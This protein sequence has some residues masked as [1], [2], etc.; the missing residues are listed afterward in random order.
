V[1]VILKPL[2]FLLEHKL[3]VAFVLGLSLL[4][5]LMFFPSGDLK[6]IVTDHIN[7]NSG[8]LYV[9]FGSLDLKLVP[10][11]GLYA[12]NVQVQPENFP[13][14]VAGSADISVS[15]LSTLMN[16]VAAT[17][18]LSGIFKGD[19][20]VAVAQKEKV[21]SGDRMI[22]LSASLTTVSVHDAIDYLRS[23]GVSFVTLNGLLNLS[24]QLRWDPSLSSQ[25]NGSVVA[26]IP[27]LTFPGQAV[28]TPIGPF[29]A[30]TVEL[31]KVAL[32]ARLNNGQLELQEVSFGSPR[33]GI[34]GKIRG[35]MDLTFRKNRDPR[36]QQEVI[37]PV[38]GVYKIN[39]ELALQEKFYDSQMSMVHG[40]LAI[41][42]LN[43]YRQSKGGS[44]HQFAFTLSPGPMGQPIAVPYQGE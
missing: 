35:K 24:S 36:T 29:E 42:W 31:G 2:Y 3:K 7:A 44:G 22:D 40:P 18:R 27:T 13:S 16:K 30:P 34:S 1:G 33:E 4:F 23:G 26:E 15:L 25:P 37:Q 17:L 5:S 11:P 39:V 41:G 14:L 9:R 10:S 8:S 21:A 12:E 43:Q 28:Q 19:V 20:E 32:Q 6:D 38:I